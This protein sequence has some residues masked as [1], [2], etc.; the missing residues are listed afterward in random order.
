MTSLHLE[1]AEWNKELYFR[2]PPNFKAIYKIFRST[3]EVF[4]HLNAESLPSMTLSVNIVVWGLLLINL[5]VFS[6]DA[7]S[8]LVVAGQDA[9][10]M[11]D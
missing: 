5:S 8:Y 10:F 7:P 1:G 3:F 11:K 9:V 4:Q 6:F 2:S